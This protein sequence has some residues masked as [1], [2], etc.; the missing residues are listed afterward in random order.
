MEG[1]L[2]RGLKDCYQILLK[3][4]LHEAQKLTGVA[5]GV[6]RLKKTPAPSAK[7]GGSPGRNR[8]PVVFCKKKPVLK[9]NCQMIPQEKPGGPGGNPARSEPA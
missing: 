2:S 3:K 9:K 7:I 5:K 8:K 4:L 6:G 1:Y